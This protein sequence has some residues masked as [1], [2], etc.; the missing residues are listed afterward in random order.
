VLQLSRCAAITKLK[1]GLG[2]WSEMPQTTAAKRRKN[3]AQ[4]RKPWVQ[5][6]NVASPEGA[7]EESR[8]SLLAAAFKLSPEQKA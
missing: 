5:V 7:K 3:A 6:G 8:N 2:K 1:F 4:R